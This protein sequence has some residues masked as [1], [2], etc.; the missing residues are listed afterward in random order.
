MRATGASRPTAYRDFALLRD[1]GYELRVD[2]VNGEARYTLIASALATEPMT[3]K[4]RAAIALAR[5]ALSAI[6]GS[7]IVR[8]LDAVL[9]RAHAV[10]PQDPR[11]QLALAPLSYHPDIVRLLHAGLTSG[12]K[13][14]IRYRGVND[15]TAKDRTLH[16]IHLQVVDQHAYLIAWDER[17]RARRTF[18]VARISRVKILR[19]KAQLHSGDDGDH[20]AKAVKVWSSDPFDVRVR[21]DEQVVRFVTEWPLASNQS[22]EPAAHGSTDV[23]ARVYG[24]EE[25]LRW[26]LRWGKHAHVIGPAELRRRVRDELRGALGRYVD[27]ELSRAL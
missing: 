7:W 19:D 15:T 25:T 6:E 5:R 18:K 24:L 10:V 16:P 8:E 26:V 4:E 14:R 13:L 17:R 1:S 21:I 22:V 9:D 2:T 12:R 3:A 20:K 11:V 27:D 23:C